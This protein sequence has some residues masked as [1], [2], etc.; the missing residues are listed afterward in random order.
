MFSGTSE[1]KEATFGIEQE[2]TVKW[3]HI[4]TTVVKSAREKTQSKADEDV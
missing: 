3:K 4:T 2:E 1:N